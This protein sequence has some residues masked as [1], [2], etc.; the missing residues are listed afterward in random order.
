MTEYTEWTESGDIRTLRGIL[1][2]LSKSSGRREGRSGRTRGP[3]LQF[4]ACN[5][6][7]RSSPCVKPPTVGLLDMLRAIDLWRLE[8]WYLQSF[9]SQRSWRT[10]CGADFDAEEEGQCRAL[11]LPFSSSH[12]FGASDLRFFARP[13]SFLTPEPGRIGRRERRRATAR[14]PRH[15]A[16]P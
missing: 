9:E 2:I 14:A 1:C 10:Q 7:G 13:I 15:L 4:R 5:W 8:I 12:H 11:P 3:P 16:V 6:I